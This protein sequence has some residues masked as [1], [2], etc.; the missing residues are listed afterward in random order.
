[1]FL[2]SLPTNTSSIQLRTQPFAKICS[3]FIPLLLLNLNFFMSTLEIYL[4]KVSEVTSLHTME[5]VFI[6]YKNVIKFINI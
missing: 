3:L 2:T 6:V 5:V 1:M 4:K